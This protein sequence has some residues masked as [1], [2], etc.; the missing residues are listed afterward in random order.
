MRFPDIIVCQICQ[1]TLLTKLEDRGKRANEPVFNYDLRATLQENKNV[2]EDTES[3]DDDDERENQP[4]EGE[5][6]WIIDIHYCNEFDIGND[7]DAKWFHL[8]PLALC[9]YVLFR[10]FLIENY[11]KQTSKYCIY[12]QNQSNSSSINSVHRERSQ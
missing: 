3:D 6:E 9:L 2:A 10:C 12:G 4:E 11:L 8:F 1:S 7:I 5:N